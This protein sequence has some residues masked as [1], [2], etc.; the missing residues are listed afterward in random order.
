M[1][2]KFLLFIILFT[3]NAFMLTAQDCD[4]AKLKARNA[5]CT[6]E[7]TEK[8]GSLAA[9]K[10]R[11]KT[12][13]D[14]AANSTNNSNNSNCTAQLAERDN[15]NRGLQY[16][17]DNLKKDTAALNASAKQTKSVV[18]GTKVLKDSL[19]AI[20]ANLRLDLQTKEEE[21]MEIEKRSTEAITQKDDEIK[22]LK[23]GL[24][25]SKLLREEA[26]TKNI[27]LITA[28]SDTIRQIMKER[29]DRIVH[30]ETDMV[31]FDSL[32]RSIGFPVLKIPFK[33]ASDILDLTVL[34]AD[35]TTKWTAKMLRLRRLIW[36]Y[37]GRDYRIKITGLYNIS[38][39]K[40]LA[41]KQAE[42]V[43][44]FLK[45]G[46]D[47][48]YFPTKEDPFKITTEEAPDNVKDKV[49]PINYILLSIIK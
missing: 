45:K 44:E 6:K 31:Y 12:L 15:L 33:S 11:V 22:K 2:Y 43:K 39:T 32:T 40:E 28:K 29:Q 35:G 27:A 21:K 34:G 47:G 13:E 19:G 46:E 38:T 25:K 14:Q 48:F 7:L 20:I 17:I 4:C 42:S 8:E 37:E 3:F 36:H 5:E 9:Q 26:S 23:E 10:R 16:T 49:S 41:K 1:S 24:V 18:P 30:D